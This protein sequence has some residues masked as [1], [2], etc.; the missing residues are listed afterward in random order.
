MTRSRSNIKVT[1]NCGLLFIQCTLRDLRFSSLYRK[2]ITNLQS[3]ESGLF[4]LESCLLLPLIYFSERHPCAGQRRHCVRQ[5]AGPGGGKIHIHPGCCTGPAITEG[6]K[7]REETM[8]GAESQ[9]WGDYLT[10]W[11]QWSLWPSCPLKRPSAAP[12]LPEGYW[13]P[14][15]IESTLSASSWDTAGAGYID[16]KTIMEWWATKIEQK[17]LHSMKYT[18]LLNR[19]R[20]M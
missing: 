20:R 8:R 3:F 4:L 18:T 1:K 13:E 6:R 9:W 12:E 19:R 7:G 15:V 5:S 17:T 2:N 14:V 10:C 11:L 16:T